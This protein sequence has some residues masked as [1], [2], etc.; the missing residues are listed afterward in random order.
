[1]RMAP[2][3]AGRGTAPLRSLIDAGWGWISYPPAVG[4]MASRDPGRRP[5]LARTSAGMVICPL[6]VT[7]ADVPATVDV[8]VRNR[9]PVR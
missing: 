7:V 2:S 1:M 5:S 8:V 6:L 4:T 9:I 3:R